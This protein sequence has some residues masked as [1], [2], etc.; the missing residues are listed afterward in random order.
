MKLFCLMEMKDYNQAK[1]RGASVNRT[2]IRYQRGVNA[3]L[4]HRGWIAD[5]KFQAFTIDCSVA[6]SITTSCRV[7]AC[8]RKMCIAPY[9]RKMHRV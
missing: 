2:T 3:I 5:D 1:A 4:L 9:P 6:V 7:N 8:D